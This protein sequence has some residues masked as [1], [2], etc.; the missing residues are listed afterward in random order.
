MERVE[1]CERRAG[2]D[3]F[4]RRKLWDVVL[5]LRVRAEGGASPKM[6]NFMKAN[7]RS[8]ME[9]WPRK[10]DTRAFIV[11]NEFLGG[12]LAAEVA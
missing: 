9:S 10:K 11:C 8:A 1:G 6:K 7:I 3:R 2:R 5:G 12:G 4:G